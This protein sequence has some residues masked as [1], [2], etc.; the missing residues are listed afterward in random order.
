M[1]RIGIVVARTATTAWAGAAVMFVLTSIREVTSPDFDSLIKSQLALLR[2]PIYYLFA[3]VCLTAGMA[4]GG[5]AIMVERK[6][7]KRLSLFLG[8]TVAAAA[9]MIV[10]YL[11]IYRPLQQ[12]TSV[13]SVAR[14]ADFHTFHQWS[15]WINAAD[16]G[17]CWIAAALVNWPFPGLT[18]TLA[19]GGDEAGVGIS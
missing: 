6:H 8:L 7:R 17:L 14:P 16:V 2:F 18:R 3:A 10:D 9:M 1:Q 19:E 4:G 11:Y 15:R 12:M 13:V 5:L